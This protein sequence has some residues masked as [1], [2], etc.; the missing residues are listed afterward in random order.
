LRLTEP[1]GVHVSDEAV[2]ER[3]DFPGD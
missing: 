3:R 1:L 2:E